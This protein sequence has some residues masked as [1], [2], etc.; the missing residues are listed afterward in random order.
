M[1]LSHKIITKLKKATLLDTVVL[2]VL[3]LIVF[4]IMAF[5]GI[6]SR[7]LF[8]VAVQQ[9][10]YRA[11]QAVKSMSYI[12]FYGDKSDVLSKLEHYRLDMKAGRV[13]A[14]G[15]NERE[16]IVPAGIDYSKV[17]MYGLE[18]AMSGSNFF[19]VKDKVNGLPAITAVGPLVS[20]SGVTV[21]AVAVSYPIGWVE[22]VISKY[23]SN[24]VFHIFIFITFALIAAIIIAKKIK[25][26]IFWMEPYEIARMCFR[27]CLLLL[28][29]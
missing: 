19:I 3:S 9:T 17:T 26:S 25:K 15:N 16:Y 4:L 13:I 22:T 8:N 14:L 18:N 12:P 24:L 7:M 11:I 21:G 28:N 29:Q 6:V 27:N 2:V 10:E 1:I 23:Y 5:G 20:G